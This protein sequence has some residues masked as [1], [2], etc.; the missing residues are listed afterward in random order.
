MPRPANHLKISLATQ[1]ITSD[2]VQ[3]QQENM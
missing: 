1:S 2:T 3:N